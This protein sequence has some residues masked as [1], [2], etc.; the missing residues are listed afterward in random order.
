MM[1]RLWAWIV[2]PLRRQSPRM[3]DRAFVARMRDVRC[4]AL[5][6][7]RESIREQRRL[8]TNPVEDAYLRARRDHA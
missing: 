6:Q 8:R 2:A 7:S 4:E 1:H 5:E 3:V